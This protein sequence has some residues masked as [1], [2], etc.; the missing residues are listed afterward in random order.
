MKQ[1]AVTVAACL[2]AA[3]LAAPAW[4]QQ[5]AVA[6]Q[7][8]SYREP[9]HA[10]AMSQAATP[11]E[12]APHASLPVFAAEPS[13][14]QRMA[15]NALVFAARSAVAVAAEKKGTFAAV[16]SPSYQPYRPA[17]SV[18]EPATA[19]RLCPP[20]GTPNLPAACIDRDAVVTMNRNG[21]V[22]STSTP[23]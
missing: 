17:T 6:N 14:G 5:G 10:V 12:S 13:T 22:S 7:D 18:P 16:P 15:Q 11:Q 4:A 21:I 19:E 8:A 20:L 23:D 1:Q 9:L 2:L 3:M